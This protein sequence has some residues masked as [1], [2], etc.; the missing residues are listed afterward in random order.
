[1]TY[2]TANFKIYLSYFEVV[3]HNYS[4]WDISH[5]TG[6]VNEPKLSRDSL[7]FI[8]SSLCSRRDARAGERR[9]R[10][11]SSRAKPARNSRAAKPRVKFNWTLHQSSH[12]FANSVHGFATKTKA[13][14][15]EI[16]PATQATSVHSV[17]IVCSGYT[18]LLPQLPLKFRNVLENSESRSSFACNQNMKEGISTALE[19]LL[20]FETKRN[21]T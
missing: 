18:H 6:K 4:I 8:R 16:P 11:I 20:N 1:M 17:V 13:L 12:G 7:K 15:R 2:T 21:E 5:S 14:A 3:L 9:S 10:H 19:V